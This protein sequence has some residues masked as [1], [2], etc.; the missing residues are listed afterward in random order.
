MEF[1]VRE[2]RQSQGMTQTE[3]ARRAGINRVTLCF[4][5]K[6]GHETSTKVLLAIAKALN[7]SI[8]DLFYD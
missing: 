4:I 1:R 2:I 6:G 5:E 3:L 8:K 7:V